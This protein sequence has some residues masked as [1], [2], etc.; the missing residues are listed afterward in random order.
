[1]WWARQA[2]KRYLWRWS[3]RFAD[4]R[5][6]NSGALSRLSAQPFVRHL[7]TLSPQSHILLLPKRLLRVQPDRAQ[8]IQQDQQEL[9]RS[10]A[11][12]PYQRHH[13]GCST[14]GHPPRSRQLPTRASRKT[15]WTRS[16]GRTAIMTPGTPLTMPSTPGDGLA[17]SGSK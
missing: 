16:I 1:M 2:S 15:K 3:C 12:R 8:G 10:A 6:S 7:L 13:Q 17:E 4:F 14:G 11:S 5:G 9:G